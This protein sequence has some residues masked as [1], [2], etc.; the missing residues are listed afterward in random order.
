[1][2]NKVSGKS[3]ILKNSVREKEEYFLL[4]KEVSLTSFLKNFGLRRL[5]EYVGRASNI[6]D[7]IYL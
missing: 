3:Q 2:R 6:L 4:A 5:R 1:M 7:L